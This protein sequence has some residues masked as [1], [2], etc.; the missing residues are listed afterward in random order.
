MNRLPP[1]TLELIRR[2]QAGD[3]GAMEQLLARYQ[4]RILALVRARL[5]RELRARVQSQDIL[6]E[7]MVAIWQNLDS[8][9]VERE[10]AFINWVSRLVENRI[11]DE[12]RYHGAQRRTAQE[13]PLGPGGTETAGWEMALPSPDATPTQELLRRQQ[14]ERIEQCLDT[15]SADHREVILQRNLGGL[16]FREI[17]EQ[18]GRSEDAARMLHKRAWPALS[19][20][21]ARQ[22]LHDA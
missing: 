21:L 17:G 11:C 7:V 16:S 2:A 22:R 12:A 20:C 9:N 10:G 5:G 8:F 6:T 19:D 15:L 18:M 14:W 4:P 13:I 3:R 1:E